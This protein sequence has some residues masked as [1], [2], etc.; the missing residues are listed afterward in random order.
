MPQACERRLCLNTGFHQPSVGLSTKA[1]PS[2]SQL[3]VFTYKK[4]DSF[5]GP[6]ST[7]YGSYAFEHLF[8]YW[9]DNLVIWV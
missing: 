9:K 6:I 8:R 1:R 5:F 3:A 7:K 4:P 2:N